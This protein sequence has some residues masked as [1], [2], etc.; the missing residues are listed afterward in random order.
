[1]TAYP[2]ET[3]LLARGK[4]STLGRERKEQIERAH[5]ICTTLM[6]SCAAALKDCQAAPPVNSG[7]LDAMKKC[8]ENLETARDKITELDLERATL[9]PLAWD[10]DAES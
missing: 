10:G 3:I 1:M 8:L 6:N 5:K 2:D 7:L 4:Y 9:K